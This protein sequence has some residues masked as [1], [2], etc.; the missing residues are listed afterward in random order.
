MIDIKESVLHC[1][2]ANFY[3]KNTNQ[4]IKNRKDCS[5]FKNEA[6]YRE[7]YEK[8]GSNWFLNTSIFS[9]TASLEAQQ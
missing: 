8:F 1:L 5:P 3:N 7:Y 2:S 4:I 6:F 9:Y